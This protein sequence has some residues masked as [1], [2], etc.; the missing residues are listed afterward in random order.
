MPDREGKFSS[1]VQLREGA[2]T[3]KTTSTNRDGGTATVENTV[4]FTPPQ[5][6]LEVIIPNNATSKQVTISGITDSNTVLV[7]YVNEVQSTLNQ[8]NGIFNSTL[9]L[10][11]GD[12]QIMV[13]AINKWGKKATVSGTIGFNP[14]S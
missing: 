6:R 3:I 5:P 2:N 1:A 7:L 12:N 14:S 8:Q 13:T 4:T 11:E 9:T 10:T